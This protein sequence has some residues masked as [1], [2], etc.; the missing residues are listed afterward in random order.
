MPEG[1]GGNGKGGPK[2]FVVKGGKGKVGKLSTPQQIDIITKWM[3]ENKHKL[4]GVCV[5]YELEVED[6][7]MESLGMKTTEMRYRDI[8]YL[9]QHSLCRTW[10]VTHG[11]K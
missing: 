4:K 7:G 5:C 8:E 10:A 6:K 1:N 3:T 9:L 2:F 11:G